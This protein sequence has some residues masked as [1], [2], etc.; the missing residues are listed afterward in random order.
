MILNHSNSLQ[1]ADMVETLRAK[2]RKKADNYMIKGIEGI[3]EGTS[4]V[5][6]I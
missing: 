2:A 6:V 1:P 4:R 3:K 5:A